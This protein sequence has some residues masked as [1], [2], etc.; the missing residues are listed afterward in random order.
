[1]ATIDPKQLQ[2]LHAAIKE[3]EE[4]SHALV[5]KIPQQYRV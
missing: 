4:K 3:N 2:L 5:E 1:M